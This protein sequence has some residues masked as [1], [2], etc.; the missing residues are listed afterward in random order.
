MLTY[1]LQKG[2]A[3]PLYAQ[4]YESIRDDIAAGR[5]S[6]GE[7]LPSRR[8]LAAHL[9]ISLATVDSAYAQLEAEGYLHAR[10]RSGF[11]VCAIGTITLPFR[12]MRVMMKWRCDVCAISAM[13]SPTMAGFTTTNCPIYVL[14][15]SLWL[16]GMRSSGFTRVLRS[17]I[18]AKMTPT[19]PS[20]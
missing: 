11:T 16:C 17:N 2:G 19:T 12:Q 14:S 10:A 15:S 3:K 5:L 18:M 13:V 8:A 1:S 7:R 4:L 20:G 9:G 6:A